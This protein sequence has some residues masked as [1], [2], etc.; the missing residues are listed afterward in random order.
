MVMCMMLTG[1]VM[2]DVDVNDATLQFTTK[3]TIQLATAAYLDKNKS[4]DSI[5]MVSNIT[6]T[7][8]SYLDGEV[9]KSLTF[10]DLGSEMR[11][12]IMSQEGMNPIEQMSLINLGDMVIAEAVKWSNVDVTNQIDD[13]TIDILK[14]CVKAMDD[15]VTIYEK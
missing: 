13:K 6:G 11:K 3:T 5:K 9:I 10:D 14:F 1:C 15:V 2:P 12:Y 7:I 8:L 4:E